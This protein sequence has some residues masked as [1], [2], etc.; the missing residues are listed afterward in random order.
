MATERDCKP[1][2]N[3]YFEA[4]EWVALSPLP[5]FKVSRGHY[6][7][8]PGNHRMTSSCKRLEAGFCPEPKFRG[9]AA[10]DLQRGSDWMTTLAP[11]TMRVV[12]EE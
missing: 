7:L 11:L 8:A 1:T 5:R 10:L 3:P 12:E 9:E 2:R 4:N 6:N